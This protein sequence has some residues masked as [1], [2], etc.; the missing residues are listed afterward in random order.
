MA[1]FST[2]D[3]TPETA[4]LVFEIQKKTAYK[5][6]CPNIEEVLDHYFHYRLIIIQLKFPSSFGVPTH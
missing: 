6:R 2:I 3:K 4:N 5:T 1:S